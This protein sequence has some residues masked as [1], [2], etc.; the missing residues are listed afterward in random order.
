MSALTVYNAIDLYLK[1]AQC[2]SGKRCVPLLHNLCANYAAD[3]R[4]AR[5]ARTSSALRAI[6]VLFSAEKLEIFQECFTSSAYFSHSNAAMVYCSAG[7][8]SSRE[9]Y[10]AEHLPLV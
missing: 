9:I 2:V 1:H 4:G 7:K 10:H 8:F 6:S 5:V 3:A